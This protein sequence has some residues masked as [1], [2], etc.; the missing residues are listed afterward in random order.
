MLIVIVYTLN[1]T[2]TFRNLLVIL[3][4][5]YNFYNSSKITSRFLNVTVTIVQRLYTLM[6]FLYLLH[7][8]N[9]II[10]IKQI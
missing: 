1:V 6:E 5:L 3:E 7:L 8:R 4:L 2:V 10:I 9:I